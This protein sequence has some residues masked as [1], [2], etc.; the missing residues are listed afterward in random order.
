M[1]IT[2]KSGLVGNQNRL[3]KTYDNFEQFKA[4]SET[5][6]I[7]TRL[8]YKTPESAW[9]HN[10]MIQ[11]S[12]EPTDLRKVR[13]QTVWLVGHTVKANYK[14]RKF[15]SEKAAAEYIG[16]VIAKKDPEGVNQGLYYIDGPCTR[17]PS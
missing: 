7:H 14:R 6:G 15:H 1:L 17:W 11:S 16:H 10:P 13:P 9:K 4:Y 2:C 12:V 8:G 5:Y 3:Q